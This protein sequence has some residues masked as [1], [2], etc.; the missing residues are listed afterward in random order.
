MAKK[1]FE[2]GETEAVDQ[3]APQ[4]QQKVEAKKRG[5]VFKIHKDKIIIEYGEGLGASIPY[6]KF[7]HQTLK[8]GD[9]IFF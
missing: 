5:K 2:S 8:E 6:D 9:L 3:E 7:K 1:F 4:V